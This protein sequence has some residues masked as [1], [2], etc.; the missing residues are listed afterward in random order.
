[1]RSVFFFY[2][3]YFTHSLKAKNK[4]HFACPLFFFIL[5]HHPRRMHI[6]TYRACFGWLFS[7]NIINKWQPNID[8]STYNIWRE[9]KHT[10]KRQQF[11]GTKHNTHTHTTNA[12]RNIIFQPTFLVAKKKSR[13]N[14]HHHY[15]PYRQTVQQR[16]V[17]II[18][19]SQGLSVLCGV[20][21][22]VY[23]QCVYK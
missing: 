9:K 15:I 1:M 19:R 4:W 14:N 16:I 13:C 22:F 6:I 21:L 23:I 18:I 12:A 17:G 10:G 8:T 2:I 3:F 11:D 7:P 5:Q 20:C